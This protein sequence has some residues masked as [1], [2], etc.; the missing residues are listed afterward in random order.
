LHSFSVVHIDQRLTCGGE[1]K[2]R[3]AAVPLLRTFDEVIEVLGG[4][5]AV[6][7]MV[8]QPASG[9]CNWKRGP[10]ACFPPKYFPVISEALAERGYTATD[11][12]YGFVRPRKSRKAA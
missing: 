7:R 10:T 4:S 8:G 11:D 12:V 2:S 3:G 9:V 1:K 5:T 6:G